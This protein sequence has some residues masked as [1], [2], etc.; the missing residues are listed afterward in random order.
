MLKILLVGLGGGSGRHIQ[1]RAGTHRSALGFS[2]YDPVYKSDRRLCDRSYSRRGAAGQDRR[3][4]YPVSENRS[5]RRVHDLFH[6]LARK[7]RTD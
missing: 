3:K 4:S 2:V 6:V 1:I 7:R 5:L